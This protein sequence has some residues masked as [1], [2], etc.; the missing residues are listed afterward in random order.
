MVART[1]DMCLSRKVTDESKVM[2]HEG[3]RYTMCD[4]CWEGVIDG[5][6]DAFARE[7]ERRRI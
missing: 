5:F 2:D 1:C 3:K 7:M 6:A 4:E